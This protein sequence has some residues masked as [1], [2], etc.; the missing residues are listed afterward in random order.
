MIS[1]NRYLSTIVA[2][3]S[4]TV[5]NA[6]N[7]PCLDLYS[8][9]DTIS[10]NGNYA[11]FRLKNDFILLEYGNKFFNRTLPDTFDC[12]TTE[13]YI[14]HFIVENKDFM[15]FRYTC[16]TSC[17]GI[18]VLPLNDTDPVR[19][20]MYNMAF[21]RE[22]NLVAYFDNHDY[23][24]LIVENLKTLKRQKIEF[25]FKSDHGE[26]LGDWIKDINIKGNKL[27]Y[28]YSN[29]NFNPKLNIEISKEIT[30]DIEIL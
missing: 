24:S 25:P 6:Q 20:I 27:Y 15:I 9:F 28:K 16:G 4:L 10:I 21:D 18:W 12:Q 2:L 3:F 8:R 26:F 14:P 11:K 17:W 5:C 7:N 23:N 19:N 22:R 13:N 30:I 1:F 29:P